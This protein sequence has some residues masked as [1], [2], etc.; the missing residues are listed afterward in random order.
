MNDHKARGKRYCPKMKEMCTKGWTKSMGYEDVDGEKI[1]LYGICAAWQ[2]IP[3]MDKERKF[4]ETVYDCAVYGWAVDLLTEI[5]S[6]LTF[7]GA[8]TD[9]VASEV[10][11]Q[12]ATQIATL[13]PEFKDRLLS[14]DPRRKM[15]PGISEPLPKIEN[16][17]G[18]K[19]NENDQNDR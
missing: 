2:P 6:K 13:S 5:S 9:K 7:N 8:S 15:L 4:S 16:K 18:S 1:P 17:N 19:N 14:N 12:H 10:A 11:K 3:L